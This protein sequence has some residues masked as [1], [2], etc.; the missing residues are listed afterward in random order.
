MK[1]V[2]FAGKPLSHM[3]MGALRFDVKNRTLAQNADLVRY[4]FDCGVNY[5]DTAPPYLDGLSEQILGMGLQGL[6]RDRFFASS[7]GYPEELTTAKQTIEAI[8]RS[9]RVMQLEKLDFFYV[10]C[11]RNLEQ[12]QAATR[13]G[14]MA[15]GLILAQQRGL[16]DKTM[17]S[18]HLPGNMIQDI[19]TERPFDGALVGI[20]VLN[21][22]FRIEGLRHLK[23]LGYDLAAM[24]PLYGGMI[25][26]H[27]QEL[28]FLCYNGKTPVRNALEFAFGLPELSVVLVGVSNEAELDEA[29]AACE[30]APTV[31]AQALETM[32]QNLGQWMD[33][34]CTGCGYCDVCPVEIPVPSY[35]QY[36]NNKQVFRW[37][38]E[39]LIPNYNEKL[40]HGFLPARPGKPQDCISCGSCEQ[41]CTQHLEIMSRLTEMATWERSDVTLKW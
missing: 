15:D 33:A 18:I 25:P 40:V 31:D 35:M 11:I 3:G 14:G 38:E 12:W 2:D 22:P 1:I 5:F 34:A 23:A 4:A 36:Y 27:A 28:P 37:S 16:I 10:W 26:R 29:V 32:R 41:A 8:Q 30:S 17:V 7:K 6:P 20:N 9:L 13:P 19:I 24:N 39:R 21:F